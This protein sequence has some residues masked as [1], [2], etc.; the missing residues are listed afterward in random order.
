MVVV[1]VVVK[2]KGEEEAVVV[3]VVVAAAEVVVEE[4]RTSADGPSR[5]QDHLEAEERSTEAVVRARERRLGALRLQE[6]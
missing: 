2:V 6:V 4:A 3:V 1:V 5:G